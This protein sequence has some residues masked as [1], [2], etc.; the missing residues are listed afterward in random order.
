MKELM[1]SKQ[2]TPGSGTEVN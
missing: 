2:A 1:P